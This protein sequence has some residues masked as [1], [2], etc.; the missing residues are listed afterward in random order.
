ELRAMLD[1]LESQTGRKYELT[2]AVGAG[3]DKIED[4]DYRAAQQYMSHIFMMTYDYNGAWS[5]TELGHQTN[6]YAAS[7][8][9]N[10]KYTTDKAVNLMLAQGVDPGKLVVGA[11]MYGRGWTGVGS[12]Q[13]NNPFTGKATGKVKGTWEDG[14]VDYRD[15][16]NNRMGSGWEKSYD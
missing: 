5:N 11:A 16:V 15:I 4:V 10:T 13:G 1:E 2:S 3:Y 14:V 6:L 9:P 12:Y 7:W 8:D